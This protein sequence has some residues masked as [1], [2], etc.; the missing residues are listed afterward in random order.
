M[1]NPEIY[2]SY[3]IRGVVPDQ[4]DAEEGYHIGR[5]YGQ[6]T[7]AKQVVV[8]R[9][10]RPSG[11]EITRELIRGLTEGGVDVV[12]IGQSTTP[13]FYF[14][15]HRLGTDGGLIVTASHNPGRY[16]GIKMTRAQAV[17][18]GGDTGLMDIRDLV[19]KRNWQPSR[20]A[21]S[22]ATAKVKQA[23]LDLVTEGAS[24]TGLRLV[25]DAGN[26]MTGLLLPEYFK[27]V[28]GEVTRLYWEPDGAFPNHEADPLKEEN[29]RDLQVAVTEH[30]A[31]LGVAFDGD[32]DRVFFATEQGKTIPG[33]IATALIAREILKEKPGATILYDLRASR[34]TREI[35]EESGGGAVMSIVGHS[36][37]KAQMRQVG[38][39]FAGEVSGHFFFTPWYA[40]SGFLALGYVLRVLQASQQPLSEIVAPLQRY[41]KTP[42][43]NFE[44][45]DKQ[46]VL[47]KL[48]DEYSDAEILELDGVSI[49]YP[50]WWA[51]VRPSNTEPLLRLNLEADTKELLRAKQ[52][53]I[54]AL[55]K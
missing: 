47:A 15:V 54:E 27:R 32:G 4:F 35:I 45:E 51:N 16:N 34:A 24:A 12:D 18:I 38:A 20:Q 30:Q 40:E 26:G 9:D 3:D 36:N 29:M 48:K 5:A 6:Y 25:V 28:G 19:E 42:E 10:M 50:N 2:R 14:A 39:V 1:F 31:D 7:G 37:I 44:V 11:E 46:A 52:Q 22:I 33:D 55:L 41:A 23:Y 53:E 21:G 43:I 17:P 13:M 8:A 49:I